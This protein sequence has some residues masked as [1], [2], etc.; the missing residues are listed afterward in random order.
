MCV[1]PRVCVFVKQ[2]IF[3]LSYH[4]FSLSFICISVHS[5]DCSSNVFLFR[6]SI[7]LSVRPL[8]YLSLK[9]RLHSDVHLFSASLSRRLSVHTS[10]YIRS[11]AFMLV[12]LMLICIRARLHAHIPIYRF[13][14]IYPCFTKVFYS[15][16]V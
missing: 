13:P 6:L 9:L 10:I 16:F 7:S 8:V 1:H 4:S 2:Y 15:L 3:V 12:S 5:Y 14:C 11:F